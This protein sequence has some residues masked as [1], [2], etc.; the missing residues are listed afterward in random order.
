V[1]SS[2]SQTHHHSH[3]LG[4]HTRIIHHNIVIARF[5]SN[6]MTSDTAAFI[7][8]CRLPHRSH[9]LIVP[10]LPGQ[11][12]CVLRSTAREAFCATAPRR[13]NI[14]AS[15]KMH[16]YP[17]SLHFAVVSPAMGRLGLSLAYHISIS[18]FATTSQEWTT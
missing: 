10:N 7:V 5:C 6:I 9:N 14:F 1:T 13:R 3:N 17:Q 4:W 11:G 8:T 2:L 15:Y 16:H 12:L 18:D